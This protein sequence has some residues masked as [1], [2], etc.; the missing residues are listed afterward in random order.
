MLVWFNPGFTAGVSFV[1]LRKVSMWNAF[2]VFMV[3]FVESKEH[4]FVSHCL[5]FFN[6]R[7]AWFI[8]YV[9]WCSSLLKYTF[10]YSGLSTYLQ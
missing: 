5:D 2:G 7:V 3:N 9:S 1:Y 8:K 10:T 6:R 4:A